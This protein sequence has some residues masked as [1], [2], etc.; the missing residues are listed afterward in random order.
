MV[1]VM[2]LSLVGCG[3]Q[4]VKEE[5]LQTGTNTSYSMFIQIE[6]GS[7]YKIVYHKDTKVM[8]AITDGSYNRGSFELLVNPDGTPMLWDN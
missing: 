2:L 7:C 6:D 4:M 1:T 5:E 8:Y 3:K